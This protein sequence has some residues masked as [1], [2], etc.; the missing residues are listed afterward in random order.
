MKTSLSS[1]NLPRLLKATIAGVFALSFGAAS[2]AADT[3][4]VPQ[5]LVK[6]GD[7]N[8][9]NPQ[10]AAGLYSRITSAAHVVCKDFSINGG[11][12]AARKKVDACV[13]KAVADAVA[14][15]DRPELTA[16]YSMKN[17][18]SQPIMVAAVQTR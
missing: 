17:H 14:Y 10:G 7:L 16:V 12:F 11:D 3:H 2:L 15:V 1:A 5:L 18:R 8:L 9:A 13:R 6:Y 4:E